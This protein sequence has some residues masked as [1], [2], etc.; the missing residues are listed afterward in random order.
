MCSNHMIAILVG[1]ASWADTCYLLFSCGYSYL[2]FPEIPHVIVP[3]PK[4]RSL[5]YIECEGMADMAVFLR[6]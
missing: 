2:K 6:I 1:I 5:S 3:D 4:Q